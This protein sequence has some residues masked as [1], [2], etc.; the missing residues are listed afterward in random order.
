MANKSSKSPSG[1]DR[2]QPNEHIR[3]QEI[4]KQDITAN[5]GI[6]GSGPKASQENLE[7]RGYQE[8]Q[9]GNPIRSSG[10]M[11]REQESPPTGEPDP[12]ES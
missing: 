2:E 9:P 1:E 7:N 3:E 4:E 6:P 11:R 8:D 10:S 5:S 12:H